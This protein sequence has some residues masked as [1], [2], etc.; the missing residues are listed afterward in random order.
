[1]QVNEEL[2]KIKLWFKNNKLILKYSK[3]KFLLMNKQRNNT[4]KN[5]VKISINNKVIEQISTIKYLGL[6]VKVKLN[7]CK[8]NKQLLS[9]QGLSTD[10]VIL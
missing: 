6:Y 2:E 1:M 8:H 10:Y 4:I 9:T 7:W 5:K 3:T